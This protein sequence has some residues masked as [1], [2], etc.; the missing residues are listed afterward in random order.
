MSLRND[1]LPEFCDLDPITGLPP[2]WD[3]YEAERAISEYLAGKRRE[4]QRKVL[5]DWLRPF[6]F[7]VQSLPNWRG[8]IYT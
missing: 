2:G 6:G 3:R 7:R 5:N 1:P 4:D 8:E